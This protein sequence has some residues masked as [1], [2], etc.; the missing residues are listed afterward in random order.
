MLT[1]N[2]DIVAT[3]SVPN[4]TNNSV[5]NGGTAG[6]ATVTYKLVGVGGA[7]CT[8]AASAAMTTTTANATLNSTNYNSLLINTND[9]GLDRL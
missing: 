3:N 6:A 1:G 2:R 7:V 4:I 9:F 5:T 8:T